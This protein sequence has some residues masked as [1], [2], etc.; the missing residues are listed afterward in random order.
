MAVSAHKAVAAR[1]IYDGQMLL[2]GRE[3][4]GKF[5]QEYFFLYFII[6]E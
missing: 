4:V 2:L 6:K 3:K 1:D 5:T